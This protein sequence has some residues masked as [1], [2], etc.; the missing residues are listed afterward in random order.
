MRSEDPALQET[1]LEA[2]AATRSAVHQYA[3]ACRAVQ[4]RPHPALASALLDLTV[5]RLEAMEADL[6]RRARRDASPDALYTSLNVVHAGLLSL[7]SA[8]SRLRQVYRQQLAVAP[9]AEGWYID[10]ADAGVL[11]AGE[12]SGMG[13]EREA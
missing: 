2:L 9:P 12:A 11:A 13:A 8:T 1:M 10:E 5:R 4:A 6:D 3:E 7:A